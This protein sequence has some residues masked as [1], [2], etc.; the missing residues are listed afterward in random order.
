MTVQASDIKFRKS[1]LQIDSGG[2][3]GRNG[4]VEVISGARHALF[5]RVTKTQRELGLIRYRKQF[6]CNENADDESAYG[7]LIYLMRPSN[8]EDRFYLAEGTQRDIQTEF[9]RKSDVDTYAA[10]RYIRTWMGCGQ[11]ETALVGGE[12]Q[13][14]LVMEADDFQFPNGGYLYLSNNTMV[15]QTVD[16]GVRVGDS[17]EFSAGSWSKISHTNNIA[18]PYG[19]CVGDGEVL[20]IQ[21]TTNEEFLQIALK[22]TTAEVIGNG[23]GVLTAPALSQL[24]NFTNGICQQQNLLPVVTAT[25][26]GV[27]RTVTM[28]GHGLC[29]GYCFEGQ[30]NMETGE[31]EDDIIW[32]TAPDNSTT[33]TITYCERA[34]YYDGNVATVDLEDQV[35]GAYLSNATFG[36]GCIYVEEVYCQS[37]DWSE[38]SALGTY[39]EVSYPIVLFNDGTVEDDWTITFTN[40]SN[41]SVTGVYTG[42]VGTGSV[43]AD[44]SPI[45]PNTG[46]P[47]FTLNSLGWGGTWAVGNTVAFTTHP[48]AVPILLENEVPTG[49]EQEPNNILPI[50]SYSE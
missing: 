19:W 22:Q 8:A 32:T 11:L 13:I 35:A 21:E 7:V 33:I 29:S 16:D 46:Q 37:E 5:P 6:W 17:V 3:G 47:Y 15:A 9:A 49:T 27:Q 48:A 41:F 26:G 50:G 2:N 43:A 23:N 12:N 10:T 14:D 1:V 25:C 31:W 42:S 28:D 36:S 34:V 45:N 30:L 39:D 20:S 18:Y 4:L 40:A 44:F 38:N 24:A